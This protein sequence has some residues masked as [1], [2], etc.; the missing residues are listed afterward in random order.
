MEIFKVKILRFSYLYT[1]LDLFIFIYIICF[2][3]KIELAVR[4]NAS[5]GR[6]D[7]VT[8][9]LFRPK[10]AKSKRKKIWALKNA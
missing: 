7:D 5:F 1:T 10:I 3:N 8:I 4:E 2:T 9:L 6:S